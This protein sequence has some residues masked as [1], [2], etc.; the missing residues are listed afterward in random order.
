M[1]GGYAASLAVVLILA[2][3]LAGYVLQIAAAIARL[4]R[5]GARR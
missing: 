4:I 1:I 2:V 3:M 5:W